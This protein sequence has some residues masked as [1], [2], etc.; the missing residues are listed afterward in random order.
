MIR[1]GVFQTRAYFG[2]VE[3]LWVKN[4]NDETATIH[5]IIIHIILIVVFVSVYV[6]AVSVAL[7]KR[8]L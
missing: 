3:F 4:N 6:S 7:G 2:A 1:F 5:L 8:E